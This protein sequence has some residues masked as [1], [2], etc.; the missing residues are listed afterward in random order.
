MKQN[1]NSEKKTNLFLSS[2]RPR[3]PA[4]DQGLPSAVRLD[5]AASLGA[6]K[7]P[8]LW[9]WKQEKEVEK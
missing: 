4:K 5:A 9:V 3:L 2:F 7:G 6:V 1:F 8:G